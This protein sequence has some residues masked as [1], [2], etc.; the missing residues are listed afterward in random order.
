[1]EGN[2]VTKIKINCDDIEW[3]YA[4]DEEYF[5]YDDYKRHLQM[6][7]PYRRI[8][9]NDEKYPL[10]LFIPGSAW[11]K[12]EMYNNIPQYEH[13]AEKGIVFAA[14]QYRESDIAVFPA[15]IYDVHHAIN[16]LVENSQRLHIDT[17]RI[18]IAGNSSGGHI[19]LYPH[20]PK[21]MGSIRKNLAINAK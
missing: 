20:L 3:L 1:V 12:Q 21:L 6:I 19:A 8:W 9:E 18:F 17:D 15:Q 4:P 11:K 16:Y 10:L 5:T 7:I 14:L 13:L 2:S